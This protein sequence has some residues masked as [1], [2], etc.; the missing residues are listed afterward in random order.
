MDYSGNKKSSLI[1]K[2]L[3]KEYLPPRK[4]AYSCKRS[5]QIIFTY[6]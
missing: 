2:K 5:S 1:H 6:T 3:D 4:S